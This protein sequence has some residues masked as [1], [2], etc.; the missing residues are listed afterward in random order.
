MMNKIYPRKGN[1]QTVYFNAAVKD[2]SIEISDDT[3]YKV[4]ASG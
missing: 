3:I 4:S 2:S 1:T